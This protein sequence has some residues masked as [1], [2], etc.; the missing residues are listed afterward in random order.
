MKKY[1][2]FLVMASALVGLGGCKKYL[3][4]NQN[5]N[6]PTITRADFTFSNA[7]ST[8]AAQQV[9]G[10]H[11]MAGSWVGYYGHSTSFT[12]GGQEKTYVFTNADFN[13][14]D[15]FYNNLTDYQY[16]IDNAARDGVSHLA[17]P[18]R[19]MQ[20]YVWQKLVD[21]YGNIPYSEALQGT[22]FLEPK[23]DDARTIYEDL[24]TK[25]TQA[26]AEIKAATFPAR[27]EAD[28]MFK[29]NKTRWIQFAN[30]LKLRILMRQSNMT[31]RDAYIQAAINTIATEGSGFITDHAL[32]QPGYAKA[33]NKMNPFYANYGFT[34]VDAQTGAYAY[35]KMGAVIVNF[36]RSTGDQFRLERIA[37]PKPGGNPSN[38]ADYVGIPLGGA[39][40]AYLEAATSPIGTM[41]IFMYDATRPSV[42]MSAAEA[43]LLRAE[44]AQR[45]GIAALGSAQTNYEDGVRWAF[46]LAAATHTNSPSASTTQADAAANA[47]LASGQNNVDWAASTDKLRAI[48]IQKWL[49]LV[50]IDGLEAWSE[51]RRTNSTTSTGSVPTSPKSIAV[52]G[53]Q[54]EPVRLF[55][56]QRE[57]NV[58]S[59][60]YV[61]VNVFTNR[62]FWDVN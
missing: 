36:L 37:R 55:Y 41:Q 19:V 51:Y 16:T 52:A 29:G 35:R 39:G 30:T 45:Y 2:S 20:A 23:Y 43:Y 7:Q 6:I 46:R 27:E 44:A 62:I 56:P 34:E 11:M 40:N 1:L 60:N 5:P 42:L 61:N 48:W 8:T 13:F 10:V 17:G 50:N 15:G 38:S 53:S 25:I 28:I 4:V 3:D 59:A 33:L 14:W 32:V 18:A 24:I 31:G 21:L 9:G 54:P 22:K 58:N 49:A 47:Y 12:G 26:I 57:Q